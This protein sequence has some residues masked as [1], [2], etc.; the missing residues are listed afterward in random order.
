MNKVVLIVLALLL[1]SCKST[2]FLPS[3]Y[4]ESVTTFDSYQKAIELYDSIVLHETSKE[5]LKALGFDVDKG[6]NVQALTYL[7][8]SKRFLHNPA[9][10]KDDLPDGVIKCLESKD[11]CYAYQ[12]Y[13]EKINKERYGSFWADAFDFRKKVHH[14]G[15]KFDAMIIIVDNVVVYKLQSGVPNIDRKEVEKQPLGPLQ[16]MDPRD[17]KRLL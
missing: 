7:D 9:I 14:T 3:S 17:V 11:G 2:H 12:F 1:T 8:V 6:Q 4:D 5:E 13:I 10:S 16:G 15:W